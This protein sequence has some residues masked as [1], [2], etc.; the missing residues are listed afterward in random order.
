LVAVARRHHRDD[1][2]FRSPDGTGPVFCVHLTW[3]VETDP[4]WPWTETYTDIADFLERWPREELEEA[5][6]D[7][8][9]DQAK[10]VAAI[11]DASVVSGG[12]ILLV[13]HYSEDDSWAFLSGAAFDVAQGKVIGM[14]TALSLDPSLRSIA[15]LPPGWTASRASVGDAWVRRADL[16][17]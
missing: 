6:D 5:D 9:F 2:L 16:D 7:W 14:G 12:P 13:I 4:T 10:N 17:V 15:D 3:A 1:V 8:P 11:A